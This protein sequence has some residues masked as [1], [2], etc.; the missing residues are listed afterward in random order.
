MPDELPVARMT[1]LATKNPIVSFTRRPI[2]IPGDVR[3][4]WRSALLLTTLSIMNDKQGT[5]L[6]RLHALMWGCS[7]AANRRAIEEAALAGTRMLE[8]CVRVDPLVNRAIDVLVG[9]GYAQRAKARLR[10]TRA[11]SSAAREIEEAGPLDA[12][13]ATLHRLSARG[14]RQR[15]DA[16]LEGDE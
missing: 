7:S 12:E 6:R 10:L 14:T 9:I 3:V 11:G 1:M 4:L 15:L 5:P 8:E 2:P 13:R 16:L